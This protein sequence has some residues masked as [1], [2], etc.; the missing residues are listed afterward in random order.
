MVVK[1]ASIYSEV[2]ITI[3]V[4]TILFHLLHKAEIKFFEAR[5]PVN[6]MFFILPVYSLLKKECRYLTHRFSGFDAVRKGT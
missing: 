5:K 6:G 1:T 3:L 4:H 2:S